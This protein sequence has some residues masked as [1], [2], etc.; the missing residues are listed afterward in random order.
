MFKNILIP[1]DSSDYSKVSIEYGIWFAKKFNGKLYGQHVIDIITLEG[2]FFHDLSGSLGFEPYLNFS[3][4][5]KEILEEKG[6]EV[7]DDFTKR[8]SQKEVES[9]TFLDTGIVS[10]EICNRTKLADLVILGQKG[11]NAG[12]DRGLLGSTAEAVTRK[13]RKPFLI[14]PKNFKEPSN[15]MLCYD[16]SRYATDAM[17]T[18]ADFAS[19]LSLPLTVLIATRNEEE[20]E[21]ILNDAKRYLSSYKIKTA[22]KTA[23][24]NPHD[25]IID[26]SRKNS[27]DFIFM[28]GH[29][30]SRIIE[31]VLG[32]TTEYVL[33]NSDCPVLMRK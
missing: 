16:G 14:T 28:G 11:L 2:P 4:K 13:C 29:G 9:C 15:T 33:R 19:V 1:V 18:A 26:F 12:F 32:S 31:M 25:E 5:M 22:F 23:K 17:Q 3:I 6:R 27:I 8:C 21:N 24:G 10:N 7:L 20:G 30:H